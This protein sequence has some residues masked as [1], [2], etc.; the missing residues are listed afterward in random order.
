LASIPDLVAGALAELLT[1][2]RAEGLVPSS[3]FIVPPPK[4]LSK[5]VTEIMNWF[6]LSH[7]P[8]KRLVFTIEPVT[9]STML[10]L[11]RLKFHG[12]Y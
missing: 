10:H 12:S 11:K 8:L 1:S 3:S 5:K 6:S 9:G 7:Q 2:Q 4:R